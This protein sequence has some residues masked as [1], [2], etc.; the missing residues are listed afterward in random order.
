MV[1]GFCFCTYEKYKEAEKFSVM[2]A[3][4]HLRNAMKEMPDMKM[5]ST[6]LDNPKAMKSIANLIS[7]SLRISEQEKINDIVSDTLAK[8]HKYQTCCLEEE[9]LDRIYRKFFT[10]AREDIIKVIQGHAAV[11]PEF[12][13]D[14]Y[15]AM[16]YADMT[17]VVQ[18]HTR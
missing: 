8:L 18:Q 15:K 12:I 10:K 16:V 14:I 1:L 9:E 6:V 3:R 17:Y 2:V 11:H 4:K 7:N 13:Q 5:F